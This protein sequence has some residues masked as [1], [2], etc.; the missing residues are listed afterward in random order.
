M[1]T[2]T[3]SS[4][5]MRPDD[6]PARRA[7]RPVEPLVANRR[8][9]PGSLRIRLALPFV[10]LVAVVLLVLTLFLGSQARDL[11][12]NR[13]TDELKA[14]AFLIGGVVGREVQQRGDTSQVQELLTQIEQGVDSR[15]TIVD[16][17]GIVIADTAADPATM[18]NHASR[19][20]IVEARR[21]ESGQ[22]QRISRTV[23][24]EY[25]YVAVVV[26]QVP[27]MVAR[28][29]VP[30]DAID[31]TVNRVQNLT[32]IAAAAA[33]VMSIGIAWFIAGRI[34]GPLEDLRR[35]AHAVGDGDLGVR[36]IPAE[37]REL[38]EV[39]YAFNAMT[40]ELQASLSALEQTRLRLEAVLS[41]LV[42]GVVLTNEDGLVLRMNNAAEN[43]LDADG[44][45]AVGKGFV[46]V[47]RDH[48][49]NQLL[50]RALDGESSQAAIEHGL[51]RRTLLTTAQVIE[52]AHERLGMVVLRDISELRRLETVRREFVAN[53]SHELRTPLTSIRALVE[54][55]EAGAI[56]DEAVSMDFLGRIVGEVDRL[57]EL[58]EDLLDLARLEAGRTRMRYERVDPVELVRAGAD[59]LRPQVERAR[60]TL[61]VTHGEEL[62]AIDV[63]RTRI[64]QVLINLVHNAIKFTPPGG[65]IRIDVRQESGWT[66]VRVA[67]TGVGIAEDEQLRLFER[68]Y[69][70]DKARNTGGTGL[71]LAIAKHIVQA[72]SGEI[73][74]QS[75][76]GEG[77]TFIVSIPDRKISRKRAQRRQLG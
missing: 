64:E 60:L 31:A 32:L 52:G 53:V 71:G 41:G 24:T 70:S 48:E 55:L 38:A 13:L 73:S 3:D 72:H 75:V 10:A 5:S 69:K 2:A 43:L 39:G 28:V 37:T 16:A 44:D 36:V 76:A 50:R 40:E 25:L 6:L 15:I 18:E 11:Y 42:D 35:Q 23:D 30:V 54:T 27:G 9:L 59:R 33:I 61:T 62:R 19:P 56:E 66:T 26:D 7:V 74:V 51:N 8:I 17:E 45:V 58:V 12:L 20:E 67:D 4:P 63:D 1:V 29:A 47:C 68:F 21:S 57:T 77:A 46:Q 65:E 22:D 49:L 14:Q 34:A